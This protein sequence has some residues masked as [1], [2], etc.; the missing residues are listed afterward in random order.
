[1]NKFKMPTGKMKSVMKGPKP[2]K[3]MKDYLQPNISLKDPKDCFKGK[4]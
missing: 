1:M 3:S 4:K 2:D